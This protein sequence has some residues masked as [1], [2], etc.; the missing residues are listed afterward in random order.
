MCIVHLHVTSSL[1]IK[2]K[3]I[4]HV[5]N[6]IEPEYF[7]VFFLGESGGIE[8][9]KGKV[10]PDLKIVEAHQDLTEL[11]FIDMKNVVILKV[12]T[13]FDTINY[14]LRIFIQ[15]TNWNFRNVSQYFSFVEKS[16]FSFENCFWPLLT[17]VA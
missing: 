1:Q 11:Y 3:T 7:I 9:I 2:I 4:H 6:Y 12:G 13:E 5:Q 10:R 8:V 14:K 16:F 15:E 17:D